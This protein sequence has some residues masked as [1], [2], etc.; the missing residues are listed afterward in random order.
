M[1]KEVNKG[2]GKPPLV[3]IGT[4]SSAGAAP[5]EVKKENGEYLYEIWCGGTAPTKPDVLRYDRVFEMH[6]KRYWGQLPVTERYASLKCPV[7]MQ[8]H[9]KEIP[10]SVAY[11]YEEVREKFYLQA[12]GDNL[13][14]TN[15]ITWMI[16]LALHEGYRDIS[17]YGVHMA[18]ESEYAYQRSSCSWAL[19]ILHGL[20]LAGE[21]IK[22]YIH[23]ESSILK[24]EYEY[25]YGEPTRQMQYV[26][27]RIDGFRAGIQ[28]ARGNMNNLQIRIHKTEGAIEEAKHIYD[29]L[30][31][32][33]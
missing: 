33:K 25:G 7:Y 14:V 6:P 3:I 27:S 1:A 29:K 20:K 13:Y 12:M 30:A 17:I 21:D 9:Y 22:L 16:L 23:E 31:G 32:F 2:G 15:T 5:Y 18:H 28:E 24:A 8:D 11:P 19:G 4:A 10:T 26:K